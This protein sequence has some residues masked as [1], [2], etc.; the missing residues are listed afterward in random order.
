MKS[1][2]GWAAASAERLL[3]VREE[4]EVMMSPTARHTVPAQ[5]RIGPRPVSATWPGV[6]ILPLTVA[7][8]ERLHLPRLDFLVCNKEPSWGGSEL[9]LGSWA[10][11]VALPG[12]APP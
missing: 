2:A 11:G 7:L 6:L 3:W 12:S 8:D 10:I 5:D 1:R 4:A 9:R